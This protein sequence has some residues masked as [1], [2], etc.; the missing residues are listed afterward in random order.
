VAAKL[1]VRLAQNKHTA[2]TVNVS[3][4]H[5]RTLKNSRILE[6]NKILGKIMKRTPELGSDSKAPCG[7]PAKLIIYVKLK[8]A[9]HVN[10]K[11][12]AIFSLAPRTPKRRPHTPSSCAFSY[13]DLLGFLTIIT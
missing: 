6:H 9:K 10:Q 13:L 8:V 11:S 3:F 7:T 5:N 4:E 2:G 1:R 12:R